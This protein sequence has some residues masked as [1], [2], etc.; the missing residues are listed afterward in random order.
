[1][2]SRHVAALLQ[3]ELPPECPRLR[4]RHATASPPTP[5]CQILETARLMGGSKMLLGGHAY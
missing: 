4:R 2:W 5:S 3:E 1:M